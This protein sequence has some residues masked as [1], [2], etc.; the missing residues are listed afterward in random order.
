MCDASV[1]KVA[2][3]TLPRLISG[4]GEQFGGVGHAH[5]KKAHK[6]VEVVDHLQQLPPNEIV[7]LVRSSICTIPNLG[8]ILLAYLHCS[9]PCFSC[10]C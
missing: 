1:V 10:F 2:S 4:Y 8:A 3:S 9:F 5:L 7:S 6:E